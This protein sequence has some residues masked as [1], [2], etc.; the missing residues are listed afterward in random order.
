MAKTSLSV[1]GQKANKLGWWVRFYASDLTDMARQKLSDANYRTLDDLERLAGL[2]N[3]ALPGVDEIAFQLRLESMEAEQ[4]VAALAEAGFLV[5]DGEALRLP[6]SS[7]RQFRSDISTSRVRE[8]RK[9]KNETHGKDGETFH[10]TA[11]TPNELFHETGETPNETDRS[12]Q[13]RAEQSRSSSSEGAVSRWDDDE[14]LR[15]LRE[16]APGRIDARCVDTRPI[17]M[18]TD[19]GIK[20]DAILTVISDRCRN[21]RLRSKLS[22]RRGWLTQ[23]APMRKPAV[24][25]AQVV[26]A[27][28]RR[29]SLE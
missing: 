25:M 24:A 14:L 5:R 19:E 18:L 13:S 23:S 11:E 20:L 8:H 6:D 27:S 16:A 21:S 22:A 17:R 2:S 4:R 15:K 7:L 10:E 12:D 26:K 28:R 29:P 3:G 9:R 1:S